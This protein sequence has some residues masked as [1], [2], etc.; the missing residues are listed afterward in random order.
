MS[1]WLCASASIVIATCLICLA[2][3]TAETGVSADEPTQLDRTQTWLETGWFVPAVERESA[4]P[5]STANVYGPAA[6][7]LAHMVNTVVGNEEHDTT[8]ESAGA[9]QTRHLFVALLSIV[10]ALCVGITVHR[11]TGSSTIALWSVASLMAIPL[12]LGMGFF[13][14]KDVP[15]ACGYTML[16]CGLVLALT[17]PPPGRRALM[18]LVAI[19]VGGGIFLM[20][21]TRIAMWVPAMAA[22]AVY[23]V[24][25]WR[26]GT[27]GQPRV[28]GGLA[29][30]V[31]VG[32]FVACA[33]LAC[34]YPNVLL[35]PTTWLTESVTMSSSYPWEGFTLT[36]GHLLDQ[37]PPWWYLPAWMVASIPT[38]IL[39]LAAAGIFSF[40][41]WTWCG[42]RRTG[43]A[44]STDGKTI[45]LFLVTLQAALLPV[46]S[47]VGASNM[48]SGLRQHLYVLPALAILSAIGAHR[49]VGHARG[50]RPAIRFGVAAVLSLA[51]VVPTIE[52]W[53]LFPFN[54][55]YVSPV[56]SVRGIDDQ[57]E[58]D[59]WFTSLREASRWVPPGEDLY[60]GPLIPK[61]RARSSFTLFNR[62]APSLTRPFA[63]EQGS[64][65]ESSDGAFAWVV[66]AKRAGNVPPDFCSVS[67]EIRRPARFS[68][69]LMG[70]VLRCDRK[71]V[72]ARA[73]S[74]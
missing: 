65:A 35:H 15:V 19:L 51:I 16:T 33:A 18:P 3:G 30:A 17:G 47:M 28:A 13:N 52:Q 8:S 57:W 54:Y 26:I 37:T 40:V 27:T 60:C 39:V 53:R 12:W 1:R 11:L 59:Y 43:W 42:I 74:S 45:G 44:A 22:L 63:G 36:A 58:T 55:T 32:S 66:A 6:S 10:A 23:G 9:W 25:G 41:R 21:G 67:A 61:G 70:Y 48:Y 50:R 34:L 68:K 14:I 56:A 20:V 2:L 72:E 62:C 29:L 71:E 24:A 49:I 31:I 46:A 38:G 64:L 69:V 73:V 4:D 5:T 7:S